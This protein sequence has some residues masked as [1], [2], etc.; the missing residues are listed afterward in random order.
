M[1]NLNQKKA[2]R[3]KLGLL[4]DE[5]RRLRRLLQK[6]EGQK[7]LLQIVD[8]LTEEERSLLNERIDRLIGHVI[9]LKNSFDLTKEERVVRQIV[10]ATSA[11]LSVQMEEI[12][13]DKLKGYGEITLEVKETLD[14]ILIEI[15]SILR[16]ME[17]IV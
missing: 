14:P 15:I 5:L 9:R 2:L 13:S 6:S 4:Q 10:K 16:Q 7:L 12:I 3:L 17:S 11:Y 1:L 8:D